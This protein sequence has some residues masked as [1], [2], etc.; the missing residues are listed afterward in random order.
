[1]SLLAKDV[2]CPNK[3]CRV[4]EVILKKA[5]AA[6]AFTARRGSY[7]SVLVAYQAQLI[8]SL[9]ENHRPSSQLDELCLISRNLLR[10]S[11]LSGQVIGRNLAALVAAHRQL[12]LSQARVLDGDKTALLD[13]P[14]TPGHTFGPV[15]DGM[16]QQSH[17]VRESTKELVRLL[18]KRPLNY[19]SLPAAQWHPKPQFQRKPVQQGAPTSGGT[20]RRQPASAFRGGKRPFKHPVPRQQPQAKQQP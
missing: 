16:L 5:Y 1:M 12:W 14:V 20:A 3:E 10:S 8:R 7:N 17:R 6:S 11:K 18:P 13:A 2:V 19:V 4:M 15:V 9:S